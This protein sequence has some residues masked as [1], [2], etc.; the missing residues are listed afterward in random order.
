[1]IPTPKSLP[2]LAVVAAMQC[3]CG[4]RAS[5]GAKYSSLDG[6]IDASVSRDVTCDHPVIRRVELPPETTGYFDVVEACGE[7]LTYIYDANGVPR[8]IARAHLTAAQ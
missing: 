2:L 8:L 4:Y 1:M 3:G 6:A 7:R 5:N